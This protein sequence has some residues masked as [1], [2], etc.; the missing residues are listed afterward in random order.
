MPV[1]YKK[2]ASVTVG[3]GGA[4][5]ITFSSLPTSYD[6]LIIKVSARR[7]S[8]AGSGAMSLEFNGSTSNL[9]SRSVS[10]NGS[11]AQSDTLTF[12]RGG[13]VGNSTDTANTFTSSDIY[14]P[15]Y[16]GNT[17]K[18]VSVDDVTE[19][20]ATAAFQ[21]LIAGLWSNTAAITSIKLFPTSAAN[22]TQ[23][24]TAVLYGVSKS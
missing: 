2:I 6:D 23:Y 3:A 12:L 18:S 8:S 24:T 17:N 10:G 20:N 11:T 9:S 4:S 19:N 1:T 16:R 21:N 5:N 14:I 22:F 15:N 7:D 13:S